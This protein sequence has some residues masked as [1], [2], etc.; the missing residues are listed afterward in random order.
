MVITL[1]VLLLGG[2]L[3]INENI[4]LGEFSFYSVCF[5]IDLAKVT[6]FLSEIPSSV[7]A[8]GRILDLLNE[9]PFI[10]SK[11][12]TLSLPEDGS[13][14]LEFNDVCFR[15]GNEQI[16]NN[17]SFKSMERKRLQL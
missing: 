5:S 7:A 17:L 6:W 10:T 16:F 4:S 15:Y 14:N 9:K 2:Y 13:G 11:E 1:V 12:N 3:T 8:A